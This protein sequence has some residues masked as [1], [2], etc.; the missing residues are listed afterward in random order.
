MASR[1]VRALR[2]PQLAVVL[3][4]LAATGAVAAHR[5]QSPAGAH[6]TKIDLGMTCPLGGPIT[7]SYTVSHTPTSGA[8]AGEVFT[9]SVRSTVALGADVPEVPVKTLRITVPVPVGLGRGG[10][11]HVMGGTFTGSAELTGAEVVVSLT[12]DDG[13]N[14]RNMAVPE[15]MIPL[16]VPPGSAGQTL[17]FAGPSSIDLGLDFLDTPIDEK[18]VAN[19]GNPPLVT[20][21]VAPGSGGPVT[22]APP[23]TTRPSVTTAPPV[24]T[25]PAVTTTRPS[26]PTTTRSPGGTGPGGG[27]VPVVVTPN[28][29]G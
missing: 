2:R 25:R 23:V 21:V 11:V 1:S 17:A 9:L 27:P 15:L 3:V 10:A 16:S 12:A 4:A 8:V 7:V 29:T 6:E 18:C 14:T 20:T 19:A 13:I 24:T 28:Y 26:G 22:T 5:V